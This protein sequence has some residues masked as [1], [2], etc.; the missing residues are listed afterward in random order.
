MKR[1]WVKAI[2]LIMFSSLFTF[3]TASAQCPIRLT[4]HWTSLITTTGVPVQVGNCWCF[5]DIT[6]CYHAPGGTG[7]D[8][9][10]YISA[11]N[12]NPALCNCS[13][14]LADVLQAIR[15]WFW[16]QHECESWCQVGLEGFRK[17]VLVSQAKCYHLATGSTTRWEDCEDSGECIFTYVTQCEGTD[18]SLVSSSS[19]SSGP[20]CEGATDGC[21]STGCN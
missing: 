20:G 2:V 10:Y 1:I 13:Q 8:P 15:N 21:V 12:I 9:E 14:N 6:Y 11:F 18:C 5:V 16:F 3:E 19:S 17:T 4:G 7:A